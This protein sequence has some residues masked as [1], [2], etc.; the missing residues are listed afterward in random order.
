V[1]TGTVVLNWIPFETRS[2]ASGRAFELH[3]R[4]Q[5]SLE[6]T[7]VVT[8]A[9]P[10]DRRAEL[11]SVR[12]VEAAP[13]RTSI[14]RVLE[15]SA[16]WWRSLAG[17]GCRLWV[18]DTLPVVR[19]GGAVSLL[20]VHDLR[21]TS[22]ASFTSV[23]RRLL[24]GL[25][26]RRSLRRADAV[27]AVSAWGAAEIAGHA[28]S[29]REKIAVIPNAA[30]SLPPSS[31]RRPSCP[32]ESFILAV[33]HLEPRKNLECLVRAFAETASD[34]PGGLVLAGADHGSAGS[35]SALARDLGL[36]TRMRLAGSVS[37]GELSNLYASCSLLVCPSL[38][39]G[40]GMT[41]LEGMAAGRPVVAS[42][43]P[44]HVEVAGDAALLVEPGAGMEH[45]LAAAI[46]S[47]LADPAL[48][49]RLAAGGLARAAGFGWDR[50]ASELLGLYERL[51]HGTE[52]RPR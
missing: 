39:E 40:F 51:M 32:G 12:F 24:L 1:A 42:A 46:R 21:H 27:V 38:Y 7:A 2:G 14:I 45:R 4:I 17:A 3:R 18:T 11:P 10:V 23:R 5:D 20:T 19:L 48:G 15:G 43:I 41:V 37:A 13:A 29:C 47:V 8:R 16:A 35:L 36:G 28:P 6:I 9:Y 49:D 26:M 52:D 22:H 34:W 33:G 50:S 25:S 30:G 44:P 31:A